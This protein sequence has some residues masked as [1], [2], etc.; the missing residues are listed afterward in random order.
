MSPS[1]VSRQPLRRKQNVQVVSASVLLLVGLLVSNWIYSI[2]VISLGSERTRANLVLDDANVITSTI[3]GLLT[4]SEGKYWAGGW[5]FKYYVRVEHAGLPPLVVWSLYKTTLNGLVWIL[6]ALILWGYFRLTNR[7]KTPE[8]GTARPRTGQVGLMDLLIVML[9]I[10]LG[11]GYWRLWIRRLNDEKELV[12]SIEKMGGNCELGIIV[13]K[14]LTTYLPEVYLTN[15]SRIV[16]ARLELP[17][18]ELLKRVMQLPELRRLRLG[19]GNYDLKQL[20]LLRELPYLSELRVSG[21][22]LDGATIAAIG[23]CKQLVSLN[24]MRTNVSTEGMQAMSQMPRLGKLNLVHTAVDFS[25]LESLIWSKTLT[26]L[27][28][29]HPGN[30]SPTD[31]AL[32][33]GVCSRIS[34]R[35]WPVLQTLICNEFD[36]LENRSCVELDISDCPRLKTIALD[37]LQ[38]FDLILNNLPAL[39]SV[40][41][42]DSQWRTRVRNTERIGC[43]PW[44][45]RLVLG[46]APK[47][48]NLNLFGR[49]LEELRFESTSTPYLGIT[50]EYRTTQ[51]D[52]R[53]G[54]T[55]QERKSLMY[56]DD[57]P[58]ESRQRW[59]N[60]LG[61]VNGP[62]KVDL[63]WLDIRGV[64]LSPLRH[65]K[66]TRELDLSWTNVAARQLIK[67]E[68][69]TSLETLI[70]NGSDIDGAGISRALA[71]LPDLRMLRVKSEN[72]RELN[73]ES[74]EKLET[75]FLE[76]KPQELGR[77][78]LVSM[79]NLRDS[80]EIHGPLTAC[81]L[82][83]IPSVQG[84]S[85]Q[86]NLPNRTTIRGLRDLRFFAAGGL[87]VTDAM[88]A[89]VL[90]CKQLRSLTLAYATRVT[91]PMLARIAELTEL[92]YIALPGCNV[93]DK[94]V[95]SLAGCKKL[96][97][98]ILDDTRVTD[99]SFVGLELSGLRQFSV[100][101]TKVTEQ[102][103]RKAIANQSIA[104]LGLAGM[105]LDAE[106]LE[107]IA[108]SKLLTEVDLSD[109]HLEAAGWKALN[110]H[111]SQRKTTL[112]FRNAKIDIKSIKE[113]LAEHDELTLDMTDTS[114]PSLAIG[115]DALIQFLLKTNE[116]SSTIRLIDTWERS[117]AGFQTAQQP[118]ISR[119]STYVPSKVETNP[120]HTPISGEI[121]H[122]PFSP[123]WK[124]Q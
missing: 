71:K 97:S 55:L 72:I 91:A 76:S 6:F 1:S 45:R 85:F 119:N 53:N 50:S 35:G 25:K 105:Q 16:S 115:N 84:L 96:T 19:G 39:E 26:E 116:N 98:L 110:E 117:E 46:D 30:S 15:F 124:P 43:D 65:N 113:L 11:F 63:S 34:L 87:G 38:R 81:E 54:F 90:N 114:D 18:E 82:V 88:V 47:L 77:L 120:K 22:E 75:V 31:H 101:H 2:Q 95:K 102:L 52:N 73:L 37:T 3:D 57:I 100:N 67:L 28:L 49:D 14:I 106:T 24:L 123:K 121:R 66:G 20:S 44:V 41:S 62:T 107:Q 118:V 17:S 99:A 69:F 93:D 13:P 104:K 64:D 8:S 27:V 36:E 94:V 10:A 79:P 61:K 12:S 68:G 111:V 56:L 29:P 78:R 70:L 7:G 83:D 74:L 59:I 48:K 109:T 21:R 58:L 103:V 40:K 122:F 9:V 60:E 86:S 33:D 4:E 80:F 42:V 23:S 32:G 112:L 108:K 89:E 51:T 5:P 92:E